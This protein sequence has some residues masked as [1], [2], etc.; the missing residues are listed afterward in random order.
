[1]LFLVGAQMVHVTCTNA[2]FETN[3]QTSLR[4]RAVKAGTSVHRYVLLYVLFW[5]RATKIL[6]KLYT[7]TICALVAHI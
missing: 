2:V 3:A 1:M 6:I 4:I 7:L 5:K